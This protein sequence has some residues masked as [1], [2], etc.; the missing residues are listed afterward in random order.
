MNPNLNIDT[1]EVLNLI[2]EYHEWK[3]VLDEA[4]AELEARK[5]A[6]KAILNDNGL[7][8][9]T[10]GRFIVRFTSVTSNRLDTGLL[11]KELPDIA[12]KYT[13]ASTS[14]RFTVSK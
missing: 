6:L 9:L 3:D 14:R 13:K 4:E 2:H 11:K 10:A 5:D 1:A 8:E 7:D 12:A